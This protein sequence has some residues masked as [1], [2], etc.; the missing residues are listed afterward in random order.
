MLYLVTGHEHFLKRYAALAESL[1]VHGAN[2]DI[3][4][5]GNIMTM[6]FFRILGWLGRFLFKSLIESY[7][8]GYARRSLGF[9]ICSRALAEEINRRKPDFVLHFF[10]SFAPGGKVKAPYAMYL[11]GAVAQTPAASRLARP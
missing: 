10:S 3:L 1:K 11:D 9:K 5:G 7:I 6:L 8:S 4:P 2:V